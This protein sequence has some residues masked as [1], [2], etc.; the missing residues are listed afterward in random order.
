MCLLSP[1]DAITKP[2]QFPI[3]RCD[4]AITILGD[5]AE[6]IWIISLDARQGYHQISVREA[7][8]EKLAFLYPMIEIIHLT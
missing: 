6:N 1:I 7:N 8:R 2:F 3:L 4:D 5:S